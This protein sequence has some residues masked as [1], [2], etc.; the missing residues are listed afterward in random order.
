MSSRSLEPA[1][2]ALLFPEAR[3]HHAWFLDRP[4]SDELLRSLYDLVKMGPTSANSQPM[5]VVFVRSPAAKERLEPLLAPGN[6]GKV[7]NAPVTAI[8][9]HDV[10]FY[11]KMPRLM[12]VKP[13]LREL[14]AGMPEQVRE[15]LAFQSATLQA[16]YLILAARSL[17]LDCGPM[18]GFDTAGVDKAFFPEGK[19]RS[20]L[21]INLGYGDIGKVYPRQPRLAFEEACRIE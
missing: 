12:P 8:V 2:R 1:Q 6:V 4:I 15:R 16:A 11:E 7:K 3:T 14:M 5:R 10:E 18:A 20:S 13:E 17:G 21:L 9:G 19:T